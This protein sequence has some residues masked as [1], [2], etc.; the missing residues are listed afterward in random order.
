MNINEGEKFQ[1]E[2]KDTVKSM[3]QSG[4]DA[5]I[6]NAELS[7][8]AVENYN[9][10]EIIVLL[11]DCLDAIDTSHNLAGNPA[12]SDASDAIYRTLSRREV[13]KRWETGITTDG[14]TLDIDSAL[15]ARALKETQNNFDLILKDYRMMLE[16]LGQVID[17]DKAREI[18]ER[19]Q[20]QAASHVKEA[21]AESRAEPRYLQPRSRQ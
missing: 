8:F 1:E 21:T 7:K 19:H 15:Q 17:K 16:M 13:N 9:L 12:H 3:D 6:L 20:L 14:Y 5:I 2:V 10:R 4:M 11:W 18:W